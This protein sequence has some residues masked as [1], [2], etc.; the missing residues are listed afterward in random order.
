[1]CTSGVHTLNV[2]VYLSNMCVCTYMYTQMYVHIYVHSQCILSAI[3]TVHTCV[4][5]HTYTELCVYV[6]ICRYH[7]LVFNASVILWKLVRPF[8]VSGSRK[9][10]VQTLSAVSKGLEDINEKDNLWRLEIM[11]CVCV[12]VCLCVCAC[13]CVHACVH[14]CVC[15]CVCVCV[16]VCVCLCVC[17]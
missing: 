7:F 5:V 4:Y 17:V 13:V 6:V 8:Q 14:T 2:H 16:F 11:M 12:C 15:V 3:Y 10:L 9:H 1:M